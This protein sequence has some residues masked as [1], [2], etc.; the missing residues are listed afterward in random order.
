MRGRE[1]INRSIWGGRRRSPRRRRRP[2]HCE[3]P[4]CAEWARNIQT[5][6]LITENIAG[7]AS[8][9][10]SSFFANFARPGQ[11]RRVSQSLSRPAGRFQE[12]SR[13]HIIHSVGD[14]P[15]AA[16]GIK[17][18]SPPLPPP[19]TTEEGE[20]TLPPLRRSNQRPRPLR[21]PIQ[22][23]IKRFLPSRD[24]RLGRPFGLGSAN[25][26]A[27]VLTSSPFGGVSIG[28]HNSVGC[29]CSCRPP[30]LAG[31]LP[32]GPSHL[33]PQNRVRR[34][35]PKRANVEQKVYIVIARSSEGGARANDENLKV[36]SKQTP[37]MAQMALQPPPPPQPRQRRRAREGGRGS[38]RD[39]VGEESSR[40]RCSL[41][42]IA[43][44]FCT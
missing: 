16:A 8:P 20:K 2:G 40:R 22:S 6:C 4:R 39:E 7:R 27:A 12:R 36:C 28:D 30:S 25:N 21:R 3:E 5:S 23:S 19:A 24:R 38:L 13:V 15:R 18:W 29:S 11:S 14:R 44:L 1:S 34:V 43:A 41:I 33:Q 26:V 9:P 10:A 32:L 17:L 35:G 31:W 42:W 37:H